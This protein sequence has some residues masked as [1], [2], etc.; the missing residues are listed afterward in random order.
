[1]SNSQLSKKEVKHFDI[2][3]FVIYREEQVKSFQDLVQSKGGLVFA[4]IKVPFLNFEN[5]PIGNQY[6]V[7]YYYSEKIEMEVLT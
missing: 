7:L 5:K 3:M 4:A 1:M 6:V 2:R